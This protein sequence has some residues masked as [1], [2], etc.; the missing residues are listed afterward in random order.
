[1]SYRSS[2]V[3]GG[4]RVR[5]TVHSCNRE[6]IIVTVMKQPLNI[7]IYHILKKMSKSNLFELYLTIAAVKGFIITKLYK[8]YKKGKQ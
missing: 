5:P 6:L 2:A 1:M 3:K 8:R 4:V 7:D